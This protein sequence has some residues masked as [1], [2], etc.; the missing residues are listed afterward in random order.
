MEQRALVL[1]TPSPPAPEH[2]RTAYRQ[3]QLCCLAGSSV[4]Q[5]SVQPVC[6]IAW[7]CKPAWFPE[8]GPVWL[9]KTILCE[10]P[11]GCRSGFGG[12]GSAA[13]RRS[14]GSGG[15]PTVE[16]KQYLPAVYP[17]QKATSNG[18][19]GVMLSMRRNAGAA[20]GNVSALKGALLNV[21]KELGLARLDLQDLCSKEYAAVKAAQGSSYVG[22]E[23]VFQAAVLGGPGGRKQ[24]DIV[25]ALDR[26]LTAKATYSRLK[27]GQERWQARL[28]TYTNG[29][30]QAAIPGG[31]PAGLLAMPAARAMAPLVLPVAAAVAIP[32]AGAAAAVAVVPHMHGQQAG[33]AIERPVMKM[34][35]GKALYCFD[36]A[37]NA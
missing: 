36:G 27:R 28:A 37:E 26:V 7:G 4:P 17:R 33:M 21:G 18:A 1:P 3:Q 5:C 20:A 34:Y 22:D 19:L 35:N 32:M 9:T 12:T 31:A 2:T 10:L 16:E 13:P 23:A 11:A 6:V 8:R 14:G 29:A 15:K 30:P 25:R 24:L